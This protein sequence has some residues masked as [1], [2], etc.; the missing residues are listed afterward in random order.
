VRKSSILSFLLALTLFA[1]SFALAQSGG[2]SKLAVKQPDKIASGTKNSKNLVTTETIESDMAEALTLI[3]D[4]YVGSKTVDYNDLF[5]SSIEGMLHTLDP[6]SNYFDAKEFEAFMTDQSSQYFGVG[7]TIGDLKEGDTTWTYIRATFEGAPAHRAGLRYGDKILEVNGVSMKNKPF[8]EVRNNLR[9]PRGTV[10]KVK[11]E[12]NNTKE[13]KII[14]IVRDAVAQP[15]IPEVYMLG[16][17]VGYIAMTGGFNQTTSAE[18]TDALKKLKEQG[19]QKLIIDLRGNGGGLVREA[20]KISSM[21]LAKGQTVFSQKGRL[22][23]TEGRYASN[24][25]NPDNTPLVLLINRGTASASEIMSGALQ[26]HDRALV[27]G[28]PAF[29]KGIITN[30]FPL[31]YN[32]A[33]LLAVAKYLTPSGRSIQRDYSSGSFYDYYYLGGS[34]HD[35]NAA[36]KPSGAIFRTDT[37]RTVYGGSGIVPDEIV[38]PATISPFQQRL[39]QPVFSFA[40]ELT[41]GRIAGFESMKIDRPI[42]FDYDFRPSDFPISDKLFAAFKSYMASKPDYKVF[43]AAQLDRERAYI[44]RQIRYELATAA[45]GSTTAFRVY[46]EDDPQI[47]RAIELLPKAEQLNKAA[48]LVRAS[49][50]KKG[51]E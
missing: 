25:P 32:S 26:D 24:N 11:I 8:T 14:E 29:G 35:D 3:Q 19:L 1:P 33:V 45:Y 5:K 6:H 10:A 43:S 17:N 50:N 18:F 40:L 20:Y 2:S 38:K 27:V 42:D 37:G 47:K 7:A 23:D 21:F 51:T 41:A 16:Q 36:P 9:G 49:A 30:P 46:N 12:R 31:P 22:P 15:S 4:Y 13:I 34:L 44:A 28:E 48:V 39:N